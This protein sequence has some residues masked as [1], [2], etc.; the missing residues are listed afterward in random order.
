MTEEKKIKF[1]LNTDFAINKLSPEEQA[2]IIAAW[3]AGAID[4]E[5][6]RDPLKKSGIGFKPDTEAKKSIDAEGAKKQADTLA[7][8]A[9]KTPPE[10]PAAGGT[11][12]PTGAT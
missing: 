2:Q 10:K 4:F 6:V 3:Q 1:R 5:E 7:Q 9:A 11:T 12:N 8:I